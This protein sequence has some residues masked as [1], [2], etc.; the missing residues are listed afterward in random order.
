MHSDI[1][2]VRDVDLIVFSYIHIFRVDAIITYQIIGCITNIIIFYRRPF[3][4]VSSFWVALLDLP[5][6]VGFELKLV[7]L[8]VGL[9]IVA[10]LLVIDL[11]GVLEGEGVGKEVAGLAPPLPPAAALI[12]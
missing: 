4:I 7:A 10:G 6:I 3:T 8:V 11:L 1:S 5:L 12:R 2:T 9:E